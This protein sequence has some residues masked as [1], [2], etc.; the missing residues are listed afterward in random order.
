MFF[1]REKPRIPSFDERLAGLKQFGIESVRTG[2]DRAVLVRGRCAAVVKQTAENTYTFE[3]TG[4]VIG[5]EIG[6]L[7]DG[8]NQKFWVTASGVRE[9]A[10]AEQLRELHAMLE[11][12]RE[13]LDMKSLYNEGLGTTNA[14]HLY[15]R[16]KGRDDGLTQPGWK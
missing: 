3:K 5:K 11:D 7:A 9:P 10:L 2:P 1:R 6:E 16:V 14:L 4:I 15:D 13:G 12:A 8:G